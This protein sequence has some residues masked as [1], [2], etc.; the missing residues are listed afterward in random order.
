[1]TGPGSPSVFTN[2]IPHIEQQVNWIS[3]CIA[4]MQERNYRYIATEAV[5]EK[6]W[7]EHVQDV[8]EV[9][10]KGSVDSWYVGA[11]VAG[12]APWDDALSRRLSCLLREVRCRRPL[13]GMKV[14][15]SDSGSD[16]RW[17]YHFFRLA[18]CAHRVDLII[19]VCLVECTS[20]VF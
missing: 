18:H 20:L 2:M 1:M 4:H 15:C 19:G 3:D 9:G 11:N 12:K 17:P 5:A 13:L 16:Q 6:A 8:G 7:W 14:L 10:L